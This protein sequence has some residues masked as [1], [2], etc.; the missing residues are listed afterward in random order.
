M[1]TP[2]LCQGTA[3]HIPLA[4][5]SIDCIITSPPYWRLRAYAELP[6][7]SWPG[8]RFSQAP[9]APPIS[10]PPWHGCLG[11]E[12]EVLGYVWHLLLV[13]REIRR[14]L[15]ETGVF[16]CN[17]GDSMASTGGQRTYGSYGG[18]VGRARAPGPRLA[19]GGYPAGTLLAIPQQVQLAAMGDGWTVRSVPVWAKAACMPESVVGSR[20]EYPRCACVSRVHPMTPG[21]AALEAAG[22]HGKS[23]KSGLY[24][25]GHTEPRAAD[26]T[27]PTCHG[28]GRL[29]ELVL[30]Q[31]SWRFT[32]SYEPILMLTKGMH[33]WA[34]GEAVKEASATNEPRGRFKKGQQLITRPHAK[35]DGFGTRFQTNGLRNPRNVL[36]PAATPTDHLAALTAWLAQEAPEVLAAY[37]EAQTNAGDVLRLQPSVLNLAHYASFPVSLP[38]VFIKASCPERCCPQCGAGW[39]P[40]VTTAAGF[41][42]RRQWEQGLRGR[43]TGAALDSDY[44][45]IG[46]SRTT[47]HDLKPTCPHYCTCVPH[48]TRVFVVDPDAPDVAALLTIEK[49]EPSLHMVGPESCPRCGLLRLTT[50]TPGV[51]ADCFSGASTTLLV[52]RALGRHAIGIEAS[53]AYIQLSRDRLGLT[54]LYTWEHGEAAVMP[55]DVSDLPLFGGHS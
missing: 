42:A 21:N 33:Y 51:V 46:Y 11:D 39:A 28:T 3:Q 15:K 25:S 13:F 8:G 49:P 34:S 31:G 40:V 1:T 10:R 2:L 54:D 12:P 22:L 14:V 5:K 20:W 4:D 32:A 18:G 52:A 37:E 38:E 55:E 44:R 24:Q 29:E 48:T 23:D 50:W 47:V 45:G 7:E 41:Q 27:C 35:N 17:L 9:G 19:T 30:R 36:L 26:P 6:A 53:P 16:W 43:R